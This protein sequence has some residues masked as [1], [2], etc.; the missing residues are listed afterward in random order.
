MSDAKQ[1]P[2]EM[3]RFTTT[4]AVTAGV[5]VQLGVA[6]VVPVIDVAAADVGVAINGYVMAHG[7]HYRL[8]KKTA[9]AFTEWQSCYL[10]TTNNVI[11]DD[12]IDGVFVGVCSNVGGK[13]AGDDMI[14]VLA[15]N[16]S[17]VPAESMTGTSALPAD[18]AGTLTVRVPITGRLAA[19][20]VRCLTAPSS[21]AGTVLLTATNGTGGST[22]LAAPFDLESIT[23]DTL[24]AVPLSAT[25]ADL[26]FEKG[27]AL[28][29]TFT[30][31]NADM[32]GGVDCVV[33]AHFEPTF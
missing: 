16:G 23:A 5:P 19:L 25:A 6:H 11:S 21:A 20:F 4:A 10:D 29:C 28:P 9:V 27:Q 2:G 15:L 14:N 26:L 33:I 7:G 22:V 24:T 31:D 17:G 32:V 1:S 12:P 18:G 30:S 3:A 13:A 8:A